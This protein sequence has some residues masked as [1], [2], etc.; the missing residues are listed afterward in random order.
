MA[1]SAGSST[2]T[3]PQAS[4]QSEAMVWAVTNQ[5]TSNSKIAKHFGVHPSTVRRW[6]ELQT[7]LNGLR[8]Q[9]EA[10]EVKRGFRTTHGVEAGDD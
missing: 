10:G 2:P 3:G 6:P 1:E 8:I 5:V 7:L 4:R 9:Q